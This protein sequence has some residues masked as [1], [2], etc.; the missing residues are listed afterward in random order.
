M[1]F[2]GGCG[3]AL[4]LCFTSAAAL[5]TALSRGVC[6]GTSMPPAAAACTILPSSLRRR[7]N[8]LACLESW[9]VFLMM[10]NDKSIALLFRLQKQDTPV[11][12]GT[13]MKVLL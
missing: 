1:T 13:Q 9:L 5:P 11:T 7:A 3:A 8:S 10:I 2:L 6:I 4:P 12:I